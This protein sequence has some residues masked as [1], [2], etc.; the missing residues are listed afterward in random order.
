MSYADYRQTHTCRG[1]NMTSFNFIRGGK[2]AGTV[3][4]VWKSRFVEPLAVVI[5]CVFVHVGVIVAWCMLHLL[6]PDLLIASIIG[7]LFQWP[8]LLV[9]TIIG[10]VGLIYSTSGSIIAPTWRGCTSLCLGK[11]LR[12]P[13]ITILSAAFA[14]NVDS[15]D[16]IHSLLKCRLVK[17]WWYSGP[18]TSSCVIAVPEE[19][20]CLNVFSKACELATSMHAVCHC[21]EQS[22]VLY[23]HDL[24]L[25]SMLLS[26]INKCSVISGAFSCFT[27]LNRQTLSWN[28]TI[29]LLIEKCICARNSWKLMVMEIWTEGK[30]I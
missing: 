16:C 6:W 1:K 25:T 11:C 12:L 19:R 22:A 4:L 15:C 21:C 8:D 20:M 9:E 27:V 2:H 5:G 3:S 29:W 10:C 7:C 23:R 17:L 28:S 24:I 30:S 18:R 13:D 26:L 14:L